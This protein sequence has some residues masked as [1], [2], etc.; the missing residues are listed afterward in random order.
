VTHLS[1]SCQFKKN[2]ATSC[3]CRQGLTTT[4]VGVSRT[5]GGGTIYTNSQLQSTDAA[6]PPASATRCRRVVQQLCYRKLGLHATAVQDAA[7]AAAERFAA[8]TCQ[9]VK[10][11]PQQH[12]VHH[13]KHSTASA[14]LI[15]LLRQLQPVQ[16]HKHAK[17]AASSVCASYPW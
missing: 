7:T 17:D 14:Q 2:A 8:P 12:K 16:L 13:D 3:R 1:C 4:N 9:T 6:L 5:T 11:Y 15:A 10:R